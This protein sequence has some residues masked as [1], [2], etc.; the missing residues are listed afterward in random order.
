MIACFVGS[1]S[2]WSGASAEA[3]RVSSGGTYSEGE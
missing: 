2:A 3:L 1:G